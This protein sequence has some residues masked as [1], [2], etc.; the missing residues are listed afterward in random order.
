MD[1]IIN[2]PNI[3]AVG[4]DWLD[5]DWGWDGPSGGSQTTLS[6]D[7]FGNVDTLVSGNGGP[8]TQHEINACQLLDISNSKGR[9]KFHVQGSVYAPSAAISLSGNANDAQWV[10]QNITA[11]QI[12]AIRQKNPKGIPGVGDE[13]VP[14]DPRKVRI[15]VCDQVSAPLAASGCDPGHELLNSVIQITDLPDVPG[16]QQDTLSWKR[17]TF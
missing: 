4:H 3:N 15:L 1:P 17:K 7:A 9:T 10:T 6:D 8:T 12:T 14:R 13:D 2:S 11:R 5:S 16:F